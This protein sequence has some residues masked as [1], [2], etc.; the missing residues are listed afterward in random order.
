[1]DGSNKTQ[2]SRPT[3][4]DKVQIKET[5]V[6]K[7]MKLDGLF[8]MVYVKTTPSAT[9]IEFIGDASAD[10]AIN[11]MIESHGDALWF[12]PELVEF[13]D[14]QVGTKIKIGN[15]EY[16]RETTGEWAEVKPTT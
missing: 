2:R 6:T 11:V 5:P 1:M 12:A 8:G 16:V 4:G 9:D 10:Y 14:H 13:V 7:S 15:R 3:F